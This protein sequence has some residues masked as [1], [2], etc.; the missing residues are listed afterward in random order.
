[1]QKLKQ[2]VD[3]IKQFKVKKQEITALLG[4]NETK[5]HRFFEG[6]ATRR[7][8]EDEDA[9][10]RELYGAAFDTKH[11]AYRAL[12]TELKKKLKSLILL[13]DFH[14]PEILNDIQQAYYEAFRTEAVFKILMGRSKTDA[15]IDLCHHHMDTALKFELTEL[16]LAASKNLRNHYRNK[17]PDPKKYEIYRKMYQEHFEYYRLENLA[18][19]YYFDISGNYINNKSTKRWVQPLVKDYL[20]ELLP[21]KGKVETFQFLWFLGMLELVF[22]MVVN[23]YRSTLAVCDEYIEKIENKPFLHKASLIMLYHQK[24]VCHLMLRQHKEGWEAAQKIATWV[25]HGS[26][27][28]FKDRTLFMQLCLHT[29]RNH[30]AL[31]VGIEALRHED[32]INQTDAVQEELKIYKGYI[33][34]LVA[35]GKIKP[36]QEE[37]NQIGSFRLNRFLNEVP[38]FAQDKRG[39]NVPVLMLQILWTLSQKDY[40]GF[41]LRLDAVNQYRTRHLK[42]DANAR[43]NLLIKLLSAVPELNYDQ[44]KIKKQTDKTYNTLVNT[45]YD[46]MDETHEVE[47]FAYDIY[48]LYLLELLEP[49]F[50]LPDIDS[51]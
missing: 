7:W 32:F 46:I 36:T 50:V 37:R 5:L 10:V 21:F 17:K 20:A 28:W 11:G 25:I 6:L 1:M 31:R 40:D 29:S 18:E 2:Y 23:D 12:K 8:K 51:V 22:H 30:E 3:L 4:D 41:L 33:Q 9:I 38:T 13:I 47:V 26:H 35:V 14:N 34:W 19:E 27:N 42:N 43:T 16:V 15:G 48:W 24:I 49:H 45:T 39:L 44:K